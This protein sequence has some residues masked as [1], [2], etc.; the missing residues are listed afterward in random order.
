MEGR[1]SVAA[2]VAAL[3]PGD[4]AI[5]Q[6]TVSEIEFSLRLLPSSRR[7]AFLEERWRTISA[8]LSRV[9]WD[10]RVSRVFG[11]RKARLQSA[12]ARLSGF[13]LAIAAHAIACRMTL[14]TPDHAFARLKLR[15]ANW[16][17]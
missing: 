13:D 5:C 7:R 6:T 2:R 17:T 12:G 9:A 14:V 10:D 4:L 8:E 3:G 1:G 16:L 15:R 11:E